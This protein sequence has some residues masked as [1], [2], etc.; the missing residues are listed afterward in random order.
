M[1]LSNIINQVYTTILHV[2]FVDLLVKFKNIVIH[3]LS[4][5]IIAWSG[6]LKNYLNLKI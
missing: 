1:L 6:F 4:Q 5:N 3:L 2:V